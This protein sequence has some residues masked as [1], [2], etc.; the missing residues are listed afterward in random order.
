M[1]HIMIIETAVFRSFQISTLAFG[2]ISEII[3]TLHLCLSFL[4]ILFS[5]AKTQN[6][7]FYFAKCSVDIKS[8]HEQGH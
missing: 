1:V 2:P 5:K 4:I 7:L 6:V 8:D 3:G